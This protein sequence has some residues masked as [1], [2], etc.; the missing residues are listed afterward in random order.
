MSKPVIKIIFLLTGLV[1]FGWAVS[2]VDLAV[3]GQLLLQ[4]GVGFFFI[5]LIYSIVTWLDTIAWK[6]T[7]EPTEETRF[8]LWN[9]WCI[10]Q[11]GEAYNI[12][13]PLGTL[14]GEPVKAQLLKE[15]HGLSLK[16]GMASQ[17]VARTTLL[18]GLIL[19]FVPGTFLILQSSIV[20][21]KFKL[22]SLVGMT[23]FSTLIFLFLLFQVTGTLS[24][25]TGWI[26]RLPMIENKSTALMHK[27]ELVDQ[28]ISSYYKQ[29][30]SRTLESILF[31]FAGWVVGLGE[32]YVTLYF[33][34]Y[35]PS[36]IDLWVIE[37]LVQL[38]RVG[39]FFIPLSIG[40]QEGGLIM[41]FTAMGMPANLGLTVS[42]VRRIKELLWVGMGLGIGSAFAFRPAKV[43]TE[44][45]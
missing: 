6:K 3:V 19:F 36:F 5:L 40:A 10:R 17:V 14:G 7:F 38:V 18:L 27:L 22:A 43:Q 26:S 13:T 45:S 1:L 34:G 4:L 23:V 11:V 44:E 15:R 8:S 39:S 12:I 21:E 29:H 28:N 33:L 2:T 31:A 37:A 9:L 20:S 16:Q 25:L 41:I 30:T 24:V 35:Q 32:L 42:F